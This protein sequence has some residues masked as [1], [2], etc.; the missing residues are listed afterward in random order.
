VKG[1]HR[2]AD[3]DEQAPGR[4]AAAE[5]LE[6]VTLAEIA[7]RVVQLGYAASMSPQRVAELADTD[8][9]WPVPRAQW[10]R[11]GAYWQLPWLPVQAYFASRDVR[12]GPKGWS[13]TQQPIRLSQMTAEQIY[14]RARLL[15]M[16][17]SRFIR[18]TLATARTERWPIATVHAPPADDP[19]Q[20]VYTVILPDD[21]VEGLAA[22]ARANGL[23]T[24]DGQADLELLARGVLHAL[25][26]RDS[27]S[28]KGT[29]R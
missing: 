16:P 13:G 26:E 28:A 1:H 19:N 3:P 17:V 12:P 2:P 5:D 11:V 18:E 7:R 22:Y 10:R 23:V 20:R 9:D 25:L 15:R 8:P 24:D 6:Q 14:I 4:G 29:D 21:L 27:Q